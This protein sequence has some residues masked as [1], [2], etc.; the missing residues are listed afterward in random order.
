MVASNRVYWWRTDQDPR[1]G[2]LIIAPP[3][4]GDIMR[5]NYVDLPANQW[6]F[7]ADALSSLAANHRARLLKAR[8]L[9]DPSRE[10][11]LKNASWDVNEG[12]ELYVFERPLANVTGITP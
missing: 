8:P 9:A 2:L 5:L 10:S 4:D 1:A 11:V 12:E 6:P 7:L 3:I